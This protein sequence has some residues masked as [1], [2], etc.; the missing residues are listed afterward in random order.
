MNKIILIISFI[1]LG[2][3]SGCEQYVEPASPDFFISLAVESDFQNDL[4]ELS[5]D[6]L[7]VLK[8][9]VTTN[10]TVS[11][12]WTSGLL[13]LSRNNHE[14]EFA[15]PEYGVKERY[16]IDVTNDTSTVL[17]RFE[18]NNKQILINQ[19]KGIILRD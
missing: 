11:L 12:A 3:L 1:F 17:I 6:N 9:R 7:P 18:K 15:V 8:S 13:K 5:L 10:Y 2:L 16:S 4:V 14:L 19:V